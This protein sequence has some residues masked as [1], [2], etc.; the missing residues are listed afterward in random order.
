MLTELNFWQAI[1]VVILPL[2]VIAVPGKFLVSFSNPRNIAATAVHIFVSSLSI[3][4]LGALLLT[5]IH[6]PLSVFY[7]IGIVVCLGLLWWHRY[8]LF[9]LK[10]LWYVLAITLPLLITYAAFTIPYLRIHN[11]LP[12]GD[13]QKAIYW[14]QD[15][16]ERPALPD[17][18]RAP[19][20]LNR[21]PVDFFTPG[22]HSLVAAVMD[23]SPAP[24]MSV[25]LLAL[26]ISVAV[27]FL[28]AAIIKELFD[29][30]PHII[31]PLL[32]AVFVLTN[33]RFLRYIREPGYHFQNL[34]GEFFL[35]ALVFYGLRFIK[36]KKTSDVI[37]GVAAGLS[38]I[39]THQF[40]AFIAPFVLIPIV[41][42]ALVKDR[43]H[44]RQFFW[45]H[46]AAA[47][48]LM[49]AAAII[50]GGG[51]LLGLHQK[52]PHIFSSDPHLISLVRPLT[53]YPLT[54]GSIWFVSGIAGFILM[55][56]QAKKYQAHY[57]AVWAFAGVTLVIL[58]L[59]QGPRLYID[60]PPVR[61][62][63]YSIVPLS[64]G[65]AYFF[66]KLLQ[67]IRMSNSL[68]IRFVLTGIWLVVIFFPAWSSTGRAFTTTSHTVQTNSTLTPE[69][70]VLVDAI[71]EQTTDPTAG[72]L[73]DDY[74]RRSSSWLILSGQPMYTR[75]AA[76][77]ERQMEE[78]EQS[79]TREELYLTL[80]DYEKIFSLGSRPELIH[81]LYKHNIHWVT[82]ISKSSNTS[83]AKNPALAPVATDGDITLYSPEEAVSCEINSRCAWLLRA[84]TLVND[85]G[86]N[87]DTFEH[88]PASIRAARLSTPQ[89]N[90]TS[91]FRTTTA[92][93]I[94]LA[95]N[96]GDFA[97]ILWDK[98][99]TGRPDT[100]VELM[101]EFAYT[102]SNPLTILTA[103]GV[104]Y[105]IPPTG[106][107]RI[108]G[109][110]VPFDE[111]GFITLSVQNPAQ[112]LVAID[113]IALGL[114]HIP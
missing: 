58:L 49:I 113:M 21:D 41:I 82:G 68:L 77:I 43:Q 57:E 93:I 101:I 61:A 97:R 22:L 4:T 19:A 28:A 29:D 46:V 70:L 74:N 5:V 111:R 23:L 34:V 48:A 103:T 99:H 105:P 26:V 96:V 79:P 67:T 92:P 66:A 9:Q 59:S 20:V 84:S 7:G 104:P 76:D 11:G 60:I 98:E 12:T 30:Y 108:P 32:A 78:A 81:L 95:F 31:P 39:F 2:L 107:I 88:L 1:W 73:I 90:I 42:A 54:M 80:L 37:L 85:I 33:F 91:T 18:S 53:E 35:F 94:P 65:A 110:E 52:I 47:V 112:E 100:A 38:L 102:P 24:L 72:I 71:K 13:S 55:L 27:A 14:A 3:W 56:W 15:V 69:Q 51:F 109:R 17:Y 86:D 44:I 50:I 114:S 62:L 25:G 40:S 64:I 87:E 89:Q 10:T 36:K 63:L 83:F 75:I 106:V 6:L 16:L 8:Q 45:K